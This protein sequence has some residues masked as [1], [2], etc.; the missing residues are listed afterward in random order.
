LERF[1]VENGYYAATLMFDESG[2]EIVGVQ[3]LLNMMLDGYF[4]F[5]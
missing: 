1:I 3:V 5:V 2:H 4:K